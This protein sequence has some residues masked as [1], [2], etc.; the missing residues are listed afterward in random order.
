MPELKSFP[1]TLNYYFESIRGLVQIHFSISVEFTKS[2]RR[3]V[4]FYD[5]L[6]NNHI[7]LSSQYNTYDPK[8]DFINFSR[9]GSK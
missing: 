3:T 4:S 2:D 1:E 8:I 7:S 6:T 5:I 9:S